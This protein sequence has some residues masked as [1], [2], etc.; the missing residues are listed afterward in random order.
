L[1]QI[2]QDIGL[3]SLGANDKQIEQLATANI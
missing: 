3:L 2:S 1:A